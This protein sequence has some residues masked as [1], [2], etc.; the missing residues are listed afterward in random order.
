MKTKIFTIII[1]C[2]ILSGCYK[3]DISVLYSRQHRLEKELENL[4]DKIGDINIDIDNLYQIINAGELDDCVIRVEDLPDGSGYKLYFRYSGEKIIYH[5]NT[6]EIGDNNNWWIGGEDT[7]VPAKGQDGD[8]GDTPEIGDNNNWWIGGK[9]TGIPAKGQDG[10]TPLVSVA[11][12]PQV[13]SDKNYYW[14]QQ[15]GN[16]P[17]EF[18]LDADGQKIR[19]NGWD[20]N[21]GTS[22]EVGI[23]QHVDGEYYWTIK[24]GDNEPEWLLDETGNMVRATGLDGE[25]GDPGQPGQPGTKCLFQSVDYISN[26]DYV[27]FV[28]SNGEKF[29]VAK[30]KELWITLLN[31][32]D[33]VNCGQTEVIDFTVHEDVVSVHTIVPDGWKA[34]VN[35]EKTADT[36]KKQ[37]R[38][39]IT[40]TSPALLNTYAQLEGIMSV[41]AFN[42]KNMSVTTSIPLEV[43]YSIYFTRKERQYKSNYYSTYPTIGDY[44]G[45][46][47]DNTREKQ[48]LPYGMRLYYFKNLNTV[49]APVILDY[50]DIPGNALLN[51]QPY[52]IKRVATDDLTVIAWG[53]EPNVTWDDYN[54]EGTAY[55]L[56]DV[57]AA[58]K[59]HESRADCYQPLALDNCNVWWRKWTFNNVDTYENPYE[60]QCW[61][62]SADVQVTF[63]NLTEATFNGQKLT[64]EEVNDL[65]ISLDNQGRACDF[66]EAEI[67]KKK[68]D[69]LPLS[70]RI[71]P[72]VTYEKGEF[73]FGNN[74]SSD[75]L[76]TGRFGTFGN[77]NKTT[78]TSV[79]L[80]TGS[81]KL[82]TISFSEGNR[83][84]I[85]MGDVRHFE[86]Y[87]INEKT[88][89]VAL[90][91][92][93]PWVV[94][95]QSVN[96]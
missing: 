25:K 79:T 67:S 69:N 95:E 71:A 90:I 44:V 43:G 58:L 5:G 16:N 87:L 2:G 51:K 65:W 36:D 32:P 35:L 80:W 21:P 47:A 46:T 63:Y 55:D 70:V 19:A 64:E 29:E 34:V 23:K 92:V 62:A 13:P 50:E 42:D 78:T 18:I 26:D 4:K 72:N 91:G 81:R 20:G 39:T 15:I 17:A 33:F 85:N 6:P 93:L 60:V 7:G 84:R 41:M 11:H 76:T 24:I 88:Y 96:L 22:P 40:L 61:M 73:S 37:K 8:D 54:E 77:H 28:L 68:R 53:N 52:K 30:Y 48:G 31:T 45:F 38:G 89:I 86:I 3:E 75:R 56:Y 66:Y 74:K 83:S 94:R 57:E 10:N 9:D 1:I 27:T 12:D 82:K 14:T 49:K 59:P